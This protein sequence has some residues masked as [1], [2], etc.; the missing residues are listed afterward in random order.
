MKKANARKKAEIS[1]INYCKTR[2]RQ[3][4]DVAVNQQKIN[5]IQERRKRKKRRSKNKF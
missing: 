1:V 3:G 2:I 4:K 5:T